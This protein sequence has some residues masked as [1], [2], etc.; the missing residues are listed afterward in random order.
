[1]SMYRDFPIEELEGRI[2]LG[3]RK[4][5]A[6][7]WIDSYTENLNSMIDSDGEYGGSP[8][9][10]DELIDT[11]KTHLKGNGSRWGE[12]ITRGGVFEGFSL[13]MT[14]WDKL[15]ILLD[16]EITDDERV[17]FFSCSC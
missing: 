14:F 12:Y 3:D 17:S 6:W 15:S 8:I 13:D 7:K 1:M 11:A 9:S 4:A 10:V 2:L 5:E 16:E